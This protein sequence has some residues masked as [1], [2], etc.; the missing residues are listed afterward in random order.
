MSDT[1]VPS[2]IFGQLSEYS[3]A[4]NRLLVDLKS[5]GPGARFAPS[6]RVKDLIQ[7]LAEPWHSELA[8]Q[9]LS[10]ALQAK[11]VEFDPA[12]MR[13]LQKAI[14]TA[15]PYNGIIADLEALARLVR[16]QQTGAY[17]RLRHPA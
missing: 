2:G 6:D 12:A 7:R 5:Q 15:S 10:N 8:I 4:L 11:S 3:L 9:A 16:S 13:R 1:G 14:T 17:S